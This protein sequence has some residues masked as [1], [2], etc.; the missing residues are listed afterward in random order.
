MIDNSANKS[1]QAHDNKYIR[2]NEYAHTHT[3]TNEQIK[4]MTST[5]P[6]Q[7]QSSTDL[8]DRKTIYFTYTP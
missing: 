3:R 6:T 1:N 7:H 4:V 5:A 8:H 2:T